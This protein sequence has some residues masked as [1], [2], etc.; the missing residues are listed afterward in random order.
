M[1]N[2]IQRLNHGA[3]PLLDFSL[4]ADRCGSGAVNEQWEDAKSA[5]KF[6]ME[7]KGFEILKAEM[8]GL[9]F[10][11]V[12]ST[13]RAFG[14]SFEVWVNGVNE[15]LKESLGR[16]GSKRAMALPNSRVLL[17][18]VM[19]GGEM[20]VTAWRNMVKEE[21]AVSNLLTRL[22]ML[23]Q[24]LHPVT[25]SFNPNSFVSTIPAYVADTFESLGQKKGWFIIDSKNNGSSTWKEGEHFLFPTKEAR[26]H[27]KN[28]DIVLD[29]LL[30]DI[31]KI[32]LYGIPSGL[33][34]LNL[35]VTKRTTE[36]DVSSY[37]VR[38]FGFDFSSKYGSLPSIKKIS[39]E[40][41]ETRKVKNILSLMLT[42]LFTTEFTLTLCDDFSTYK[43]LRDSTEPL[44]DRLIK[45][46]TE[47]VLARAKTL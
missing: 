3:E 16:G 22:G 4:T 6:A 39:P 33:D 44:K 5:L 34:S 15:T 19:S 14:K 13:E 40:E 23:T 43:T 29:P 47:E 11:S 42:S 10:L 35:A 36:S 9:N 31:A 24:E 30:T 25:V 2:Q 37:Q 41:L 28:W 45:K 7:S 21:V 27:E 26:L 17:L 46:Y 1:A 12:G 32:C 8:D 18:P 38:Y 20:L